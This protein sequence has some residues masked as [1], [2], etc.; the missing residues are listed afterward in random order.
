[1]C[2]LHRRWGEEDPARFGFADVAAL[3]APADARTVA[4]LRRR[5]ALRVSPELAAALDA[6]AHLP[7]GSA[8]EVALRAAA[9]AACA[10]AAAAAGGG[11]G[12]WPLQMWHWLGANDGDEGGADE[13]AAPG[14]EGGGARAAGVAMHVTR[15]TVFY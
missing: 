6:R 1:V 15:D 11:A 4:A 7:A 10:A 8:P 9:V 3:P 13:G 2:D 12:A 5:G 14:A